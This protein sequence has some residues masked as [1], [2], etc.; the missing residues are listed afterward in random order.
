MK[1]ILALSFTLITAMSSNVALAHN[2]GA[3]APLTEIKIAD[4]R[5]IVAHPSGRVVYTFDPDTTNVS[6]CYDACART[7]PPVIMQSAAGLQAPMGVTKRKTGEL[8]L[9]MEGNP[10]YFYIGDS[11]AGDIKGDGLGNVWHIIQD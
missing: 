2:P 11:A 9:T 8:Q 1:S 3:L 10:L 6:N 4:G 5:D 7:W